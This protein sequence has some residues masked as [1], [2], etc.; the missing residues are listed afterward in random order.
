MRNLKQS[1]IMVVYLTVV[2][3]STELSCGMYMF[4]FIN[5]SK[6]RCLWVVTLSRSVDRALVMLWH[7]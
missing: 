5:F 2:T 7:Q 1:V 3:N 6:F 4:I